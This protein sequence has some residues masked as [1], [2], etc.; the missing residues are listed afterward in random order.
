MPDVVELKLQ[1]VT[2]QPPKSRRRIQ[3]QC[4]DLLLNL[5]PAYLEI[6][7]DLLFA[8]RFPV[9]SLL[10]RGRWKATQV[11]VFPTVLGQRNRGFFRGLQVEIR[12]PEGVIR[13]MPEHV[14]V[15]AVVP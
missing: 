2:R 14:L 6:F 8:I 5:L 15:P 3:F 7:E 1:L 10:V 11:Q 12:I 9:L 4:S 13:D